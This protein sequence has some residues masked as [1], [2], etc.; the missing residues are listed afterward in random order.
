MNLHVGVKTDPVLYRYSYKWLFRLME[1]EG[2]HNAQ[3]GTFFEMYQ[4]PDDFFRELRRCAEDHDVRITSIFTAHR[5]L[6]GFFRD[7]GPGWVN[8]A[9]QNF[10]RAIVIGALLGADSVGS[11]PGAVLRDR[12]GTKPAGMATYVQHMK[13]LLHIAADQG[14]SWLGIEAMSCLAEPPTLPAEQ[15]SMAEELAAYHA[16][17]SQETARAGYCADVAHGYADASRRIVHDARALLAAGLP[18]THELHLKNT[19]AIFGATFGFSEAERKRGI[20]DVGAI[21]DFL[22]ANASTLPVTELIGYLEIGGPKLGR[23]YS[24]GELDGMLRDSLRHLRQTFETT[25][26]A[27]GSP[28]QPAAQPAAIHL[29]STTSSGAPEQ[30]V[31]A[32]SMMCADACNLERDLRRLERT[33]A[34]WLHLDV[35]DAHFV[36]NMP[37]GLGVIQALRPLTA[38]PLDVHLMVDNPDFFV[39]E[40]S[41]I[42]VQYVSVHAEACQHLDRTLNLI[43]ELGMKAGVALNP[44]TPMSALDYVWESLDYV[45]LMTV[46]PGFAGQKLVGNALRKIADCRALRD[47][48]APAVRIA[49]DGNVSFA[50]IPGMVAAGADALVAGT[51]SLFSR[52]GTLDE[53]MTQT[54]T[55]IAEGIKNRPAPESS[56]AHAA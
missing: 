15:R 56:T 43:R 35:M 32:P 9:R 23:D 11:N 47:R 16:A 12:M 44:A 20:I 33:G 38:L 10:E 19:D 42:G 8:V 45:L 52:A 26:D 41:R 5:E 24:D 14:V 3:L 17:H 54:R 37:L 46:N 40:L 50:N 39:R 1:E 25:A 36:P 6:G 53:N 18:W 13:E 21:R 48:R 49:V 7:D 2:V 4:L 22:L 28:A 31:V 27:A 34:D 30:V 55:A 29:T 51:S